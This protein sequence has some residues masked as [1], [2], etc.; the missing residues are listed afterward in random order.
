MYL[1]N[2]ELHNK[3]KFIVLFVLHTQHIQYIEVVQNVSYL[4][5]PQCID[6]RRWRELFS[7]LSCI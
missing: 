3:D 1:Y 4:S 5:G 2:T 6:I 7:V